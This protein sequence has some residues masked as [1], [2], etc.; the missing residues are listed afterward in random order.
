MLQ[1]ATILCLIRGHGSIF[2][3]EAVQTVVLTS[4][5]SHTQQVLTG[6]NMIVVVAMVAIRGRPV[7]RI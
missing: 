4:T 1:C 3:Q 5:P 2:L 7:G 6:I